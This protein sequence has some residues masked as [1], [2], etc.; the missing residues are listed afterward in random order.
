M[1][2]LSD[3]LSRAGSDIMVMHPI[4]IYAE[5]PALKNKPVISA[6]ENEL[7]KH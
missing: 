1:I 3:I 7:K 2:Q 5:S 6:E 4:E